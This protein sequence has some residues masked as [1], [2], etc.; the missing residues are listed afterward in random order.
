MRGCLSRCGIERPLRPQSFQVLLHL[1]ERPDVLV[2]KDE[3]AA[4]VWRDA[5][6]SDNALL[7]CITEVRKA[8]GDDPRQPRFIRTV[9]KRGYRFLPSVHRIP[10]SS[11]PTPCPDDPQPSPAEQAPPGLALSAP[12]ADPAPASFLS[13][14]PTNRAD[15][16]T[17]ALAPN[18]HIVSPPSRRDLRPA[19]LAGICVGVL[20]ALCCF[21]LFSRAQLRHFRKPASAQTSTPSVA[22]FPF[23]NQTRRPELDWLSQGLQDMLVANLR[24][25]QR[26][27]ILGSSTLNS[28][29]APSRTGSSES[30]VDAARAVHATQV[31]TGTVSE[32]NS[33]LQLTATLH[34]IRNGRILA[35]ETEQ[36][37]DPAQIVLQAESLSNRIAEQ[38][39]V[40]ASVEPSPADLMTTHVDAYRYYL[41]GVDRAHAF[42][43]AQ[44]IEF[45]EKAI[46]IDPQFAM[47]YARIGYTYAVAD[48]L[49]EEGLPYLEK[50]AQLAT[51]IPAKDRMYIAAWSAIARA[52]YQ[53]AIQV[54]SQITSRYPDETE[55]CYQMGRLLHGQEQDE[56]A[57]TVLNQGLKRNPQDPNLYNALGMS[58]VGLHRYREAIQAHMQYEKLAPDDP[59]AHDSLGMT[60]QQSG[61]YYAAL[62]EYSHALALDPEFEPSIVHTGD[63]DYQQG[64][65]RDAIQQYLRYVELTHSKRARALG[66]G[67]LATV[68][69]SMGDA[70]S[71]RKAAALEL[72][73]DSH[74]AWDSF[75]LAR[76]KSD[77]SATAR[78]ERTLLAQIPNVERG[79][80]SDLRRRWYYRGYLAME[81]GDKESA[82]SDF[83]EALRHLPPSSGIDSHED[84]LAVAYRRFGLFPAAAREYE[85]ILN[86]NPNYP[87][88]AY[89]LASVYRQ[90]GETDKAQQSLARFLGSWTS[91][92]QN[93]A[94]IEDARRQLHISGPAA[95][96]AQASVHTRPSGGR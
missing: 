43:N 86:L 66:Y 40:P 16:A 51:R 50:A 27:Q 47:A 25:S 3:L 55:A 11:R 12:Q 96:T 1:V 80:P 65:Y 67:N 44:A 2:S 26:L 34:D 37:A 9:P 4:A 92:D 57:I 73:N 64:R 42:Q 6:V 93:I 52:Q 41:L 18:P 89:Y 53:Q 82:I 39:G 75:L 71:E 23:R 21:A 62:T 83:S 77:L 94:A 15:S 14:Q 68:Y 33:Q 13:A 58:L 63:V 20:L 24:H 74:A 22:V 95:V 30:E 87:L 48:F 8:L 79:S 61:D 76:Q 78:F 32:A 90:L 28:Q 31:V 56:A 17:R 81:A 10:G 49:P 91:A 59:N 38:L 88:A 70:Q 54:F 7:Q 46:H 84:C 19:L 45:F 72:Q 85:R 35:V 69:R 5:F 29:L 36:V 60:Y